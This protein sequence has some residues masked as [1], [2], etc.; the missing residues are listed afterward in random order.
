MAFYDDPESSSRAAHSLTKST[1]IAAMLPKRPEGNDDHGHSE[2][3]AGIWNLLWGPGAGM[4]HGS[5]WAP[6]RRSCYA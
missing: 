6:I 1:E 2:I 3:E 5:P 4:R